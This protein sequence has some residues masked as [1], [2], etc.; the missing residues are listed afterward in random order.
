MNKHPIGIQV[1][2]LAIYGAISKIQQNQ[3]DI[4]MIER[5]GE[6][7]VYST[8]FYTPGDPQKNEYLQNQKDLHKRNEELETIAAK[9]HK[10]REGYFDKEFSEF[11][12][13]ISTTFDL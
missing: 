1:I 13:D 9:L 12:K 7:A 2:D 6:K 11:V 10:L 3:K 8:T 5:F 4:L